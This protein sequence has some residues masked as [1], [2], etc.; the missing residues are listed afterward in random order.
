LSRSSTR[1]FH[2]G[3]RSLLIQCSRH[4]LSGVNTVTDASGRV[5]NP[6]CFGDKKNGPSGAMG[7]VVGAG[8][9]ETG[10]K[11]ALQNSQQ[12]E[13]QDAPPQAGQVT[14]GEASI[15]LRSS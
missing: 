6:A 11:F 8:G 13:S 15:S 3:H 2:S 14:T 5:S 10:V 1:G 12:A 4:D 9:G 7:Q